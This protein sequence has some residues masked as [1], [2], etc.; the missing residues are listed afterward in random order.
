MKSLVVAMGLAAALPA[1]FQTAF[2]ACRMADSDAA[3]IAGALQAWRGAERDILRLTPTPLPEIVVLDAACTY[4]SAAAGEGAPVWATAPHG[5]MA[6]LPDGRQIPAAPIAFAAPGTG[7][8]PGYFVMS[9]PSVWRAAGVASPLGLERLMD[10]VLLHEI[11]HTRQF[12][13]VGPQLA[14]LTARYGL[15]DDLDDNSLQAK[16]QADPAYVAAYENERDL[17]FA[18]AAASSDGEARRLAGQAL[19]ALRARRAK[20]FTG[21]AAYWAS[22]DDIFLTMEGLGQWIAYAWLRDGGAAHGG[23]ADLLA[24][25]RR[26]GK[27]WTQD[28]GLALFLVVDRLVPGWQSGAFAADPELAEA[29]LSR[30]AA[31]P[32]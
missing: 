6:T 13:F 18:A 19:A 21:D 31:G 15:P 3:W 23:D 16:F 17:L 12:Y 22:L 26:G 30:A 2:A 5:G 25:V 4:R 8:G 9:L 24:A 27:Q 32:D 28:E 14:A 11:M 20:W 7:A 1:G 29:L 10:G